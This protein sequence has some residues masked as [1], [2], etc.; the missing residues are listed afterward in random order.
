MKLG[1]TACVYTIATA[2][3]TFSA[4]VCYRQLIKA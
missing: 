3:N 1:K 4:V 2:I